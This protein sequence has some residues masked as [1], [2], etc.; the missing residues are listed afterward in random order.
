MAFNERAI[1]TSRQTA[2]YVRFSLGLPAV[3]A[4]WQALRTPLASGPS[5]ASPPTPRSQ[6]ALE[7]VRPFR[8]RIS[9][10]YGLILIEDL[11]ELSYPWATGLAI[12]GLIQHDYRFVIPI[13]AAWILRAAIGCFRQMYD[14]RLYTQV[15][16]DIVTGTIIRQRGA[17]VRTSDVAAR[18]SMSRDRCRGRQPPRNRTARSRRPRRQGYAPPSP[19][20]PARGRARPAMRPDI[21]PA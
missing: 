17:G 7:A 21:P 6:S 3:T 4:L 5:M 19:C 2:S 1:K 14:T 10:T 13:M 18:S 9:L 16:N 11:L 15:Y 12:D 20:R 8:G